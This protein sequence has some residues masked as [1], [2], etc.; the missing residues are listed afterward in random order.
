MTVLRNIDKL[1]KNGSIGTKY[2]KVFSFTGATSSIVQRYFIFL[3]CK[4]YRIT[5]NIN[6]KRLYQRGKYI[7]VKWFCGTN[8]TMISTPIGKVKTKQSQISKYV[9]RWSSRTPYQLWLVTPQWTLPILDT[10]GYLLSLKL[11]H[12]NTYLSWGKV[13]HN[14]SSPWVKIW[15]PLLLKHGPTLAR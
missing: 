15:A 6:V 12:G 11:S 8:R 7:I 5:L 1:I 13:K 4:W 3:I 9:L 10:H 14:S 2:G